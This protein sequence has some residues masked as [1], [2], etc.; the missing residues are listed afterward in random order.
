MNKI[1]KFS[2]TVVLFTMF[3]L[4]FKSI[5]I[6]FYT[7]TDEYFQKGDFYNKQFMDRYDYYVFYLKYIPILLLFLLFVFLKKYI[8]NV[9]QFNFLLLAMVVA[10]LFFVIYN[11]SLFII[12]GVT[13]IRVLNNLFLITTLSAINYMIME[14]LKRT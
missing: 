1:V 10:V 5:I 7:L 8:I 14:I 13:N 4:I 6:I 12:F 11:P 9:L 2:L 3:L